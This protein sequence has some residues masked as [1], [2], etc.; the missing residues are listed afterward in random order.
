MS[1]K[2]IFIVPYFGKLPP[3]F[4]VWMQSMGRNHTVNIL[5]I[6]DLLSDKNMPD[7]FRLLNWSFQ[8]TKDYIQKKF[9]F[10]ISLESPYKLCDFKPAYGYIFKDYISDYDYWGYCD[11]DTVF[12]D[13]RKFIE[14]LLHTYDVIG[15]Y[16][17][18]MLY[19][20][21]PNINESFKQKGA[22]FGYQEVFSHKQIYAFD[23]ITG[24]HQIFCK[25]SYHCFF[26]L[27]FMADIC[28]FYSNFRMYHNAHNFKKQIFLWENGKLYMAY[29]E[30]H[31]IKYKEFLYIHFQKRVMTIEPNLGSNYYILN[32]KFKCRIVSE[33]RKMLNKYCP[34]GLVF[35]MFCERSV[36][37]LKKIWH[38]IILD[39]PEQR[40]IKKEIRKSL[41]GIPY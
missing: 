26:E 15:K 18:M 12:G 17:H 38:E 11:I 28:E 3:Y 16:G 32:N 14:P 5:F 23:E 29:L 37:T 39:D 41:Y 27:D 35:R 31:R 13:I 7:N 4:D 34:P 10:I 40:R 22:H 2:I 25:E 30:K 33:D 20:N 1:K 21:C 19:R 36:W 8:V 9:P 6:S 24:V